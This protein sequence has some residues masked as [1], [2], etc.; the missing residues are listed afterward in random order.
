MNNYPPGMNMDLVNPPNTDDLCPCGEEMN[1]E[2]FW[3]DGVQL[4]KTGDIVCDTCGHREK[5]T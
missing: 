3:K 4:D 5:S 1:Y 2:Y